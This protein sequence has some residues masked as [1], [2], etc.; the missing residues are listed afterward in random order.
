MALFD[1]LAA[2]Q[3]VGEMNSYFTNSTYLTAIDK[4]KKIKEKIEFID[5]NLNN[6]NITTQELKY[7]SA[8]AYLCIQNLRSTIYNSKL[9]YRYYIM[10]LKNNIYKVFDIND[11][12]L[13]KMLGGGNSNLDIKINRMTQQA[14]SEIS[15]N[16]QY[17]KMLE[18]HMSNIN[19]GITDQWSDVKGYSDKHLPYRVHGK[20]LRNYVKD[21]SYLGEIK[22]D[23]S[24][25][26][27]SFN[28]GHIAEAFDGAATETM[29]EKSY[30]FFSIQ[31]TIYDLFFKKYLRGDRVTGFKGGDNSRTNTS[32]KAN[33]ATLMNANFIR[34]TLKEIIDL[35][36]DN[37]IDK[38]KISQALNELFIDNS[39]KSQTQTIISKQIEDNINNL[40]NMI[41]Q[42]N[43][44]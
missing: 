30:N 22:E 36:N 17:A 27:K 13:L 35:F 19:N 26:F 24:L 20:V 31:T 11:I 32:I 3:I 10:D 7:F 44:K 15:K 25:I 16:S 43:K 2:E 37:N 33:S 6:P 12:E 29:E 1:N 8:Q 28:A 40:L 34:R 41:Q 42:S 18:N 23:G 14:Q 4:F 39:A 5:K 9:T 21:N 38:N